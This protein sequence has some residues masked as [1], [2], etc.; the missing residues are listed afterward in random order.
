MRDVPSPPRTDV[1]VAG[2]ETREQAAERIARRYPKRRTPRV[3]GVLAAVLLAALFL[4]WTVWTGLN[5]ANPAISAQVSSFRTFD[6]RVE[7]NLVVQRPDPQR[8]ARCLVVA[9]ATNFE[10]VG[11]LW[12]EVAPGSQQRIDVPL[13]VRTFRRATSAK[14]DHCEID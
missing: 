8:A 5:H 10:T 7:V 6:D 11:E 13:S 12:A 2:R 1:A 9:Q 3:V 4:T 14:L